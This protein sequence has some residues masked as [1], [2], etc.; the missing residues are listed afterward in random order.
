MWKKRI[1]QNVSILY[2]LYQKAHF[3]RFKTP[4]LGFNIEIEIFIIF[5]RK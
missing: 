3:F 5:I 4:K 2:G 1:D